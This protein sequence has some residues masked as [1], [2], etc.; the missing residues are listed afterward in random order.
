MKK[1]NAEEM[2]PI[3]VYLSKEKTPIAWEQR[4]QS[5]IS[6]GLDRE[7]A[8]VEATGEVELELYYDQTCGLFAVESEAV[9]CTPIYNPYTGEELEEFED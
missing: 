4:V 8:E 1:N 7:Q 6:S 2:E 5:L 3:M 9:E